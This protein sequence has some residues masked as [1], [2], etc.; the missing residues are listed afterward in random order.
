MMQSGKDNM[1][2][3]KTK[4]EFLNTKYKK[5]VSYFE[6]L[7][8]NKDNYKIFFIIFQEY[9]ILYYLLKENEK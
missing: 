8:K 3:N 6:N 5:L 2:V 4:L 7:K 9:N 1:L